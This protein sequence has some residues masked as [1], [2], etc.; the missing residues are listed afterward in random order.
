M[1][2]RQ[3]WIRQIRAKARRYGVDPRAALAVA[4]TEGLSGGVGDQGTSYGPFQLHVGGALPQ[5]RTQAWAES[6][7]GIDYA[8]QQIASVAKGLTGPAAIR[9]I[10]TRF[11]R[12]ADPQGQIQR[13]LASY[14]QFGGGVAPPVPVGGA[15]QPSTLPPRVGPQAPGNT[16]RRSL[17]QALMQQQPGEGLDLLGL[18]LE[19]RRSRQAQQMAPAPMAAPASQSSPEQQPGAF[20]PGPVNPKS[21]GSLAEAFYDPLG[22]YDNGR[23]GGAIGGHGKHVHLSITN[24]QAMLAAINQARKMGLDPRENLYSENVDPVHSPKSF[25]YRT[26]PGRYGGKQLSKGVDVSGDARKMAGYYRW[27]LANLR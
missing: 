6:P 11:E 18:A 21:R 23:F 16:Y 20:V 27:A 8:L 4:S 12:P 14:S 5:G 15:A 17:A 13:A 26:F 25:H 3:D 7:A 22:S 10:V 24:P 9:N 2:Y 19:S 1:T